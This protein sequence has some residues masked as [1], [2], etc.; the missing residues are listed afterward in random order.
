MITALLLLPVFAILT[1]LY[2]YLL[3][4]RKWQTIDS[5]VLAA[6]VLVTA[7]YIVLIERIEFPHAGSLWPQI[8]SVAGAYGILI[9]GLAA[10][11]FWRVRKW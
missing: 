11:L 5:M 2:W 9:T 8:V 6:V 7:F 4:G 10:G 3:P 1:W